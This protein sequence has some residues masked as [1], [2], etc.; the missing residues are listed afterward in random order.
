M[1]CIPVFANPLLEYLKSELFNEDVKELL[2]D[3]SITTPNPTGSS[4]FKRQYCQFDDR[5]FKL[6]YSKLPGTTSIDSVAW[7]SN[8][9][10]VL[11]GLHGSWAQAFR[12]S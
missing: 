2:T 5:E 4:F 6:H 3:F 9:A 1:S 7:Q 8:R 10:S 12:N 11:F